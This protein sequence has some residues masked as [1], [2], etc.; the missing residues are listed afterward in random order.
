MLAQRKGPYLRIGTRSPTRKVGEDLV[1]DY[2]DSH[3]M[4]FP[5]YARAS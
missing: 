2:P 5:N 3:L 4:M 1:D